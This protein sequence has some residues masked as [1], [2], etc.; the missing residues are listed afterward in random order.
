MTEVTRPSRWKE[1]WG[2]HLIVVPS[3][4]LMNWVKELKKWTPGLKVCAYFGNAEERRWKRRGWGVSHA[5]AFH[6]CLVSYA[7]ALQDVQPLHP[8]CR[9]SP[10]L[11]ARL[12]K[13][14]RPF[15]LRRLKSEVER[16]LP[17]KHEY[18]VRCPLSR[19]QQVL[20]EEFM[21]RR[22]TQRVLKKGEY[23]GMMGVLMQLRHPAAGRPPPA[24]LRT[25]EL[26]SADRS[27]GKVCNH[28]ELFEA[29]GA[30]TPLVVPPLD[31]FCSFLLPLLSLWR[32]ELSLMQLCRKDLPLA[33]DGDEVSLPAPKRRR[34]MPGSSPSGRRKHL[35]PQSQKFVDVSYLAHLAREE[36]R[37]EQREAAAVDVDQLL[38][39]VS[40]GRP[41]IG[42]NGLQ[43]LSPLAALRSP[44]RGR[45]FLWPEPR[46]S[47]TDSVDSVA[48]AEPGRVPTARAAAGGS[49]S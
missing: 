45:P 6:I 49:V 22:E 3:S 43:L 35:S 11:V 24:W 2:P 41:W 42:S 44:H 39:M 27:M 18:V 13:V 14:L 38:W 40:A 29:R 28:P 4:V 32:L 15:M 21:Q 36:R 5:D 10:D 12:H 16:Q 46:R 37:R 33:E 8:G 31:N 34:V 9:R 48:P 7:V 19:R 20:Y 23:I 26:S 1:V 47:G 25:P 17:N 30:V